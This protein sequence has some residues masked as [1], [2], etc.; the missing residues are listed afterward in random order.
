MFCGKCGKQLEDEAVVCPWCGAPTGVEAGPENP[1]QKQG[2]GRDG[3]RPVE[4]RMTSFGISVG[5][6]AMIIYFSG[7]VNSTILVLVSGDRKSV[8]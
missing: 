6:V 1:Q 2:N 5:L 8:V 4:K 7:L 3:Y